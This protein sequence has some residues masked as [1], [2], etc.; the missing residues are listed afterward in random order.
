MWVNSS[1]ECNMIAEEDCALGDH[2]TRNMVCCARHHLE[3]PCSTCAEAER[4]TKEALEKKEKEQ[5][6][7]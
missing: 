5:T 3:L 6:E 4:Q 2:E 1:V 7:S